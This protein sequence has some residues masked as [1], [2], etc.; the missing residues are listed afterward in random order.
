MLKMLER[1]IA[2]GTVSKNSDGSLIFKS[3][4]YKYTNIPDNVVEYAGSTEIKNNDVVCLTT[5]DGI[6]Y[7]NYTALYIGGNCKEF[8][9][10][11]EMR[12]GRSGPHYHPMPIFIYH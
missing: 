2:D 3:G 11:K 6:Q 9:K 1:S 8:M 4:K 7:D 12:E 10:I 5:R